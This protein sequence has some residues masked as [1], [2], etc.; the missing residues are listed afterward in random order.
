MR[1]PWLI[2]LWGRLTHCCE[3]KM[4]SVNQFA[5][6]RK[7]R[8]ESTVIKMFSIITEVPTLTAFVA[9]FDAKAFNDTELM[10]LYLAGGNRIIKCHSQ[11]NRNRHNWNIW[12]NTWST[13]YIRITSVFSYLCWK[14]NKHTAP[15]LYSLCGGIKTK[16][17][18]RTKLQLT[19]HSCKNLTHTSKTPHVKRTQMVV[20]VRF[21][22]RVTS[23]PRWSEQGIK[24]CDWFLAYFTCGVKLL[25]YR[26]AQVWNIAKRRKQSP[27]G[28]FL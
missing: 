9:A 20:T 14:K 27:I 8:T 4:E 1:G 11:T 13:F 28:W 15:I 24:I 12:H 10:K 23:L 7:W 19:Y 3:E 6:L 21:T 17:N 5:K 18:V 25:E 2:H 22:I 16:H 26:Y